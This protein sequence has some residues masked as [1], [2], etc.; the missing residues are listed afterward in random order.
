MGRAAT[1]RAGIGTLGSRSELS[2]VSAPQLCHVH[3]TRG[4]SSGVHLPNSCSSLRT[5]VTASFRGKRFPDPCAPGP[6]LWSFSLAISKVTVIGRATSQTHVDSFSRV[7]GRVKGCNLEQLPG[8]D[9]V[10]PGRTA[11][12]TQTWRPSPAIAVNSCGRILGS[13]EPCLRLAHP[14][15]PGLRLGVAQTR[16]GPGSLRVWR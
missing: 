14:L 15:G 3:W 7:S 12:A 5:P 1:G 8:R 11:D 2:R 16:R 10:T 13:P 6:S 9:P 4:I